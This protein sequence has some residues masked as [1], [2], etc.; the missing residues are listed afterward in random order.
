[1]GECILQGGCSD[2]L[3]PNDFVE[4]LL[5]KMKNF[6]I[7]QAVMYNGKVIISLNGAR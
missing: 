2:A 6:S 4:Y 1:V 5:L 7:S 3:F